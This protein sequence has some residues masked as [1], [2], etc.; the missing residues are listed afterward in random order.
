MLITRTAALKTVRAPA[1]SDR[2]E[3]ESPA[4]ASASQ[5]AKAPVAAPLR[6]SAQRDKADKIPAPAPRPLETPDPE[7]TASIEAVQGG[8]V[9]PAPRPPV[10][11][12]EQAV[13]HR[14]AALSPIERVKRIQAAL[15]AAQ[16]AQ[17]EPDGIVGEKTR[18]AI[19]TFQALEGMDVNGEPNLQLLRRMA[20]IGLVH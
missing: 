13:D 7:Q 14:L 12:A 4:A 8:R 17:L 2:P 6:Q 10:D 19:R 20:R 16:V 9:V 5:T 11:P 18:T 3:P 1:P 15:T